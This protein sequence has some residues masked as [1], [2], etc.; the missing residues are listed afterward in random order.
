M[1]KPIM[2][3]AAKRIKLL[4][5]ALAVAPF[6]LL[7]HAARMCYDTLF[8]LLFALLGDPEE[9]QKIIDNVTID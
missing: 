5:A 4:L 6:I 3:R 9:M 7:A 8:F 1:R 2:S